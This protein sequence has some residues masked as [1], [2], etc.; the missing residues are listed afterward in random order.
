MIHI[1][2]PDMKATICIYKET[3]NFPEKK[4]MNID[5]NLMYACE[6]KFFEHQI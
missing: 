2:V 5:K 6:K 1:Y 3:Q 4:L